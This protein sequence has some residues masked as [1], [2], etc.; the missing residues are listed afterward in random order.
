M[1][2]K[3]KS[4]YYKWKYRSYSAQNEVYIVM[5]KEGDHTFGKIQSIHKTLDGA[6]NMIDTYK[7]QSPYLNYVIE[8][9][10]LWDK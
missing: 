8:R 2:S 3:L 9:Y 7:T 4:L 10:G 1:L 6:K 5:W